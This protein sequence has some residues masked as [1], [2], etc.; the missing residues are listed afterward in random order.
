MIGRNQTVAFRVHDSA[1]KYRHGII[2]SSVIAGNLKKVEYSE[3]EGF[4]CWFDDNKYPVNGFFDPYAQA[5]L[6]PVKRYARNWMKL[7]AQNPLMWPGLLSKKWRNKWLEE[8]DHYCWISLSG[9]MYEPQHYVRAGK[10]VYKATEGLSENIRQ[11][12]C[13]FLEHDRPYRYPLQDVLGCLDKD[14]LEKHRAREILRLLNMFIERDRR[15]DQTIEPLKW[16]AV[17]YLGWLAYIPSIRKPIVT[18]L[19]RI[20]PIVIALDTTD[21]YNCLLNGENGQCYKYLGLDE[22]GMVKLHMTL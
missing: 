6:D 8:F 2:P 4:Q 22:K 9:F 13:I 18:F 3:T 10:E 21:L 17:R 7:I 12:I 16:K 11:A 20:D 1:Y 5:A 15:S 14:E 19:R